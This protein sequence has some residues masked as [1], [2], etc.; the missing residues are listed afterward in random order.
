MGPGERRL[1][2]TMPL[3]AIT[4]LHGEAGL[5][6]RFAMETASFPDAGR[7][8]VERALE[9]AARL[10]AARAALGSGGVVADDVGVT[11][12]CQRLGEIDHHPGDADDLGRWPGRAD[13]CLGDGRGAGGLLFLGGPGELAG[14]GHGSE[15]VGVSLGEPERDAAQFVDLGD[16]AADRHLMRGVCWRAGPDGK[17]DEI[18]PGQVPPRTW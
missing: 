18:P 12:R 17:L 6:M 15:R 8:W 5:R 7:L 4:A 13:Q 14:A 11:D 3:H 16:D 1:L 10:H 2:V 9:L